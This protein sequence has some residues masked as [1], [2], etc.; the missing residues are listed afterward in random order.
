MKMADATDEEL[1]LCAQKGCRESFAELVSRHRRKLLFV[2]HGYTT[3]FDD[4]EDLVQET[5][6]KAY[7]NIRK[8]K[9]KFKFSTWLFTIAR[10]LAIDHYHQIR[11]DSVFET[12]ACENISDTSEQADISDFGL[13]SLAEKL[14]PD[15]YHVLWFK[16]AGN[17]PIKEISRIMGKSQ[18]NVKVLLY[19]ARKNLTK[20]LKSSPMNDFAAQ[21]KM[22]EQELYNE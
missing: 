22:H 17:M 13:W 8:Y 4:A 7:R 15:Q 9:N 10:H 18:V 11:R 14:S 21:Q 2:M 3:N 12:K 19:R 6:V 16:Y 20:Q 5:F 1:A